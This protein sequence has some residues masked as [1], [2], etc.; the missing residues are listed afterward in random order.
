MAI[1]LC[2][3]PWQYNPSETFVVVPMQGI[4]WFGFNNGQTMLDGLWAGYRN[5]TLGDF[6]TVLK[7]IKLLGF[8]G[9]R[10]PFTFQDLDKAPSRN[11]YVPNCAV[12][13][14]HQLTEL[15]LF[16]EPAVAMH[17]CST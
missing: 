4:N 6:P 15:P 5:A 13:K 11:L 3:C 14:A 16:S 10:L 12:S 9:I 8:N 1:N 7:R 17:V 2:V